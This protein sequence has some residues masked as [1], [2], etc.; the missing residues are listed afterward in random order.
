MTRWSAL[1]RPVLGRIALIAL[2]C[3]AV[4]PAAGE[5]GAQTTSVERTFRAPKSTVEKALK[6]LQPAMSGHLPTVEG[7]VQVGD[8]PLNRYQ[9]A[10]YQCA[11]R[12]T[13][14]P[15]GAVVRVS[16]NVTA[17]YKDA[18]HSGYQLL[19]SNGRIETDLLDQLSDQVSGGSAQK[20]AEAKAGEKEAKS[21]SAASEDVAPSPQSDSASQRPRFSRRIQQLAPS[22]RSFPTTGRHE[23][24]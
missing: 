10:F 4:A 9:R 14:T 24:R 3:V 1:E 15:A 20:N 2:I 16:A 12:V 6:Q 13:E 5:N 18:A 23:T 22:A 19:K 21:V 17:W 8:H 7:F 11:A